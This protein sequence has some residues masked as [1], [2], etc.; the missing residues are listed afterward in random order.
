[1]ELKFRNSQTG[2]DEI[3][4]LLSKVKSKADNTMGIFISMSGFSSIAIDTASVSQT[5]L[6][7]FDHTHIYAV[8]CGI[9]GLPDLI[10]R[11]RR[12]AS[13]TGKAFLAVDAF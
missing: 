3:D 10:A 11:V 6:L 1:M 8:L 7:L 4:V 2:A 13:Q 12:H 9:I 5:P